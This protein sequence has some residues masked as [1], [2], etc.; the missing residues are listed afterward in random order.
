MFGLGRGIQ[1]V[2]ASSVGGIFNRRTCIG[3]WTVADSHD[4]NHTSD[5]FNMFNG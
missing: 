4:V 1:A 3:R 2:L 5:E